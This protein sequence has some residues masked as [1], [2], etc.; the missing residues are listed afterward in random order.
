MRPEST[1]SPQERVFFCPNGVKPVAV[2]R[3]GDGPKGRI[4]GDDSDGFVRVDDTQGR[5]KIAQ[6]DL[7][8]GQLLEAVRGLRRDSV[9]QTEAV[10]RI[11]ERLEE[12][13]KAQ[14][15]AINAIAQRVERFDQLM[16][17]GRWLLIGMGLALTGTGVLAGKL[18]EFLWPK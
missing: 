2:D 16:D 14:T 10:E 11:T 7:L 4:V 9:Q 18:V 8:V 3:R 13:S 6:Q 12:Y 17:K 15:E 5:R 1:G